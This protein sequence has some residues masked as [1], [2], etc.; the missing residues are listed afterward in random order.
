MESLGG[1]KET[2]GKG[3]GAEAGTGWGTRRD[4]ERSRDART[5]GE[6]RT[7]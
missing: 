7:P 6:D 5:I 1:R 2:K 4:E 3:A